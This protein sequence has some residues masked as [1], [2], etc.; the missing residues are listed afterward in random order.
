[1]PDTNVTARGPRHEHNI[2]CSVLCV[3]RVC[4]QSK[5]LGKQFQLRVVIFLS[6]HPTIDAGVPGKTFT[7]RDVT[8]LLI[9]TY[10]HALRVIYFVY[11]TRT[12]ERKVLKRLGPVGHNERR[13]ICGSTRYTRAHL[14][15]LQE[16]QQAPMPGMSTPPPPPPTPLRLPPQGERVGGYEVV[17]GRFRVAGLPRPHAELERKDARRAGAGSWRRKRL[18]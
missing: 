17:E 12:D 7:Q 1:M 3:V 13:K 8:M 14:L 2:G 18:Q 16:Q 10:M 15:P 4:S 11:T 6:C 5:Q 9:H